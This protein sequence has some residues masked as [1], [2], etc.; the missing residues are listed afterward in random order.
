[1]PNGKT[2]AQTLYDR[3]FDAAERVDNWLTQWKRLCG[4][5]DCVRFAHV[6]ERLQRQRYHVR[7]WV[8]YMTSYFY[9]LNGIADERGRVY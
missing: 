5:V 8:R 4:A 7:L 3:Y 1:M 6:L 9:S 2:L